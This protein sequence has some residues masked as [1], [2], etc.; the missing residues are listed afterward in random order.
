MFPPN[1]LQAIELI[2]THSGTYEDIAQ[3][4]GVSETTIHNW[5]RNKEFCEAVIDRARE[6][7]RTTLP[8]VQSKLFEMA[9]KGD[10]AALRIYFDY[11][12]TIEKLRIN[13]ADCNINFTWNIPEAKIA[14]VKSDTKSPELPSV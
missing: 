2:A 9:K 6:I 5:K 11:L 7:F 13:A 12:A 3:T 8:G 14:D 1:Q 4:V 10:P